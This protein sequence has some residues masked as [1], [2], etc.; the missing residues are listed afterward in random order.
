MTTSATRKC[1]IYFSIDIGKMQVR[2]VAN[3]WWR[4]QL[5]QKFAI[6]YG[7][8]KAV[9]VNPSLSASAFQANHLHP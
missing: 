8:T 1:P 9:D 4:W 6:V 5:E 3:D 2:S 7:K